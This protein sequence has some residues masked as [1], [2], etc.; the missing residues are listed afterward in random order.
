MTVSWKNFRYRVEWLAVKAAAAVIPLLPRTLCYWAGQ[1]AGSLAFALDRPNRRVAL[2]NLEAALGDEFSP[3]QRADIARQSYQMFARTLIDLFWTPRLTSKNFWRYVDFENVDRLRA[4][5][6]SSGTFILAGFHYGNFEWLNPGVAWAGL[7]CDIAT[8]EF[9]NPLLDKIFRELRE[10][11]G[12]TSVPRQ[13]AIIRLYRILRKKG[14]IALLVD[15]TLAPQQ[16]TVII[17][18]FGLKKVVPIAHAWLHERT[19]AP[20]IPLICEPL[21][22]GRWRFVAHPK[23]ELPPGATHQQIAQACWDSFEPVV[24]RNPAPWLWMY[25][26]WRYRPATADPSCY[27]F[28]ANVSPHFEKRLKETESAGA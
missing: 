1:F 22:G 11:A 24:R 5:T 2:S 13:G 6:A 9:K 27:P 23:I 20:L 14:R 3:A 18:S 4:D 8:Q 16:P 12:N 19:G 10:H 7:T 17:E 26:H 28:Y 21:P 25:K 15:T